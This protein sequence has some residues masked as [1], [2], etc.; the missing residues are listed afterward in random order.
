MSN[1]CGQY[2]MSYQGTFPDLCLPCHLFH[3]DHFAHC[4]H[5]ILDMRCEKHEAFMECRPNPLMQMA[6]VPRE[7]AEAHP[8]PFFCGPKKYFPL[9]VILR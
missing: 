9:Y 4:V 1:A 8:P 5:F 6:A 7:N 3:V 2:G